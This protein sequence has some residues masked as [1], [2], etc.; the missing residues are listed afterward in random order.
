MATRYSPLHATATAIATATS[1]PHQRYS[2][3]STCRYNRFND[4][5]AVQLFES[6]VLEV[7]HRFIPPPT[8]DRCGAL[9]WPLYALV[10][11]QVVFPDGTVRPGAGAHPACACCSGK[12]VAGRPMAC[13]MC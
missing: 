11:D 3:W 7:V 2:S 10:S 8:P 9:K 5:P 6:K 12:N 13:S 1:P 4:H